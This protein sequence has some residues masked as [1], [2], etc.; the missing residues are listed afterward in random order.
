MNTCLPVTIP[1]GDEFSSTTSTKSSFLNGALTESCSSG[2]AT[3]MTLSEAK[4][5]E[6]IEA[7]TP[8]GL[9][10]NKRVLVLTPDGTRTCPLP[11]MVRLLRGGDRGAGRPAR[12]HGGPGDPSRDDGGSRSWSSTGSPRRIGR[13]SSAGPPFSATA[14]TCRRPSGGSESSPRTRWR[15]FPAVFCGSGCR[16]ISTRPSS[17]TT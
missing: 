11:M 14:G 15:R 9:Y 8:A 3:P 7:G 10:E 5:R 12:F 13:D 1:T 4:I 17:T 2:I 6:I 16:S